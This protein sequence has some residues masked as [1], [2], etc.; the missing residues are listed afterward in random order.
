ME[1]LL[2]LFQPGTVVGRDVGDTACRIFAEEGDGKAAL[3]SGNGKI[4]VA[5]CRLFRKVER[6]GGQC[7]IAIFVFGGENIFGAVVGNA[8]EITDV[9]IGFCIIVISVELD[10]VDR[11]AVG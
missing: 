6:V 2:S 4:D 9:G 3:F 5:T 1:Y 7:Y 8:I 10:F 11:D